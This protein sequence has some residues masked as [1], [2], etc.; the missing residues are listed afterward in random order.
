M[1]KFYCDN[2]TGRFTVIFNR[3]IRIKY[4]GVANVLPKVRDRAITTA[5]I[6]LLNL[7]SAWKVWWNLFRSITNT[8]SDYLDDSQGLVPLATAA[9]FNMKGYSS[10]TNTLKRKNNIVTGTNTFLIKFLTL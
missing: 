6:R 9:A 4:R 8:A 7:L 10:R 3:K 2:N 1:Q 5:A